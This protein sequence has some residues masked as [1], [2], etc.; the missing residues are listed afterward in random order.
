MTQRPRESIAPIHR[1]RLADEFA[2]MKKDGIALRGRHFVLLNLSRPGPS[3]V[4]FIASRKSVGGAVQ[5]NRSRRRLR[6]IVRRRWHQVPAEG[7]WLLFIASRRVL[8]A[9]HAELVLD[10]ERSLRE[11]GV[12]PPSGAV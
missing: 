1:L 8:G 6:E 11:A 9:T 12:L 4:G 2:A 7:T 5:R 3:K 10:V